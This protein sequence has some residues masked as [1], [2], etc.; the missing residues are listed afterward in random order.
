M[1]RIRYK[2]ITD[3]NSE[4]VRTFYH[5]NNGAGYIIRMDAAMWMVLDAVTETVAV[6]GYLTTKINAQKEVKD[7]LKSLGII[8]HEERRK[9]VKRDL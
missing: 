2:K 1:N 6:S 8:L 7:A 4:S 9:R 5:P 3:T